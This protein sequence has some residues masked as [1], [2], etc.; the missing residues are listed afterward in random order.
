MPRMIESIFIQ[1]LFENRQAPG[2]EIFWDSFVDWIFGQ[3][4]Q[5]IAYAELKSRHAPEHALRLLEKAY[6][7]TV[8]ENARKI[9][10]LE[11]LDA[12]LAGTRTFLLSR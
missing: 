11:E 8:F 4:L 7:R 10:A 5:G 12:R 1:T 9:Q 6:Y 2:D 3:Q